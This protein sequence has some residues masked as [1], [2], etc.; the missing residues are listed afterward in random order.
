LLLTFNKEK[1][2]AITDKLASHIHFCLQ[3][4]PFKEYVAQPFIQKDELMKYV[5]DICLEKIDGDYSGFTPVRTT[6]SISNKKSYLYLNK[7]SMGE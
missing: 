5:A 6:S 4:I 3:W 7:L 2:K 1:R